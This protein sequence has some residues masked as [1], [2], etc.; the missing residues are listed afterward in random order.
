MSDSVRILI[1]QTDHLLKYVNERYHNLDVDHF[2]VP[3]EEE[4]KNA[5]W[6]CVE[7]LQELSEK[8][9][10]VQ[11]IAVENN[12]SIKLNRNIGIWIHYE[13]E[14]KSLDLSCGVPGCN[15][16]AI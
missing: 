4:L 15:I 6:A 14:S 5:I 12:L 8:L 3:L 11:K 16:R 9:K 13:E 7:A 2:P 1:D 10:Q